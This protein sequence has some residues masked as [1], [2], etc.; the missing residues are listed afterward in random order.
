MSCPATAIY[1]ANPIAILFAASAIRAAEKIEAAYAAAQELR[2]ENAAQLEKNAAARA[3]ASATERQASAEQLQKIE[4]RFAHLALLARPFGATSALLNTCPTRPHA[5]DFA[6]TCAYIERMQMLCKK[7]EGALHEVLG[8]S[9]A[10]LETPVN[11][12]SLQALTDSEAQIQREQ[13][14]LMAQT[15][16]H[17]TAKTTEQAASISAE[18][19]LQSIRLLARLA[20]LGALPENIEQLAK[21]FAECQDVQRAKLLGIELRRAIQMFEAQ[22]VQEASALVLEQTLKDLGYQVEP[23]GHTLFVEGGVVHFR[24]PGWD[25]YLVRLRLDTKQASLNF[26]VIRAV[27]AGD[28]ERSVRDHLAEDRW[29]SEFPAFLKAAGER[30]LALNVTREMGPGELPVQLVE[31]SQLPNCFDL[32]AAEPNQQAAP[33]QQKSLR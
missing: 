18:L 24:R 27:A 13:A 10:L 28:N 6:A 31:R 11:G 9:A 7:L 33:L 12:I 3:Q 4:A 26:N 29:C 32:S 17:T 14:T 21:E 25:N 30:G 23:I 5:Q 19:A 15:A 22:A 20:E 2:V 8:H 1:G 16:A